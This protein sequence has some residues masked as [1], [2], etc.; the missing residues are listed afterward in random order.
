M[1]LYEL[2]GFMLFFQIHIRKKKYF[3]SK[4]FKFVDF[5]IKLKYDTISVLKFQVLKL[6]VVYRVILQSIEKLNKTF[7]AVSKFLSK[8]M[9]TD[10]T[11]I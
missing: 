1:Y 4:C 11:N 2:H 8:N 5:K 3:Y 6:P 9:I 10:I 7:R